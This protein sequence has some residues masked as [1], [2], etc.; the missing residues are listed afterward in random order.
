MIN[1][2]LIS[3]PFILS[4]ILIICTRISCV[5]NL[6]NSYK[7]MKFSF[8]KAHRNRYHCDNRLKKNN[9]LKKYN[10]LEKNGV[11]SGNNEVD[12]FNKET[13]DKSNHNYYYYYHY[14]NPL[15]LKWV[16]FNKFKNIK[17]IGEG[18]F[19]K[20]Y[21]ETWIDGNAKYDKQNDG[22]WKKQE[23]DLSKL[24]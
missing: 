23:S 8:D 11:T 10:R 3:H 16:P 19:A 14:N 21:S 22:S 12:K 24:L 9:R 6:K 2:R 5:T 13:S 7:N 1:F 17:K 20:V 18:G 15:F 4:I